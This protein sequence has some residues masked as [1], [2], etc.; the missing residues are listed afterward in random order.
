M[1]IFLSHTS[2][3]KKDVSRIYK[4]LKS[5]GHIPWL[6]KENISLGESI[7]D[8]IN[9]G[10]ETSDIVLVFLSRKYVESNWC[11]N[12][13]QASFFDQVNRGGVIIV[14]ILLEKCQIPQ[15]LR[16]KKYLDFRN[17]E[18]YENNVANLIR[19][20]DIINLKN[21]ELETPNKNTESVLEY[22][23]ELLEEL[24]DESVILPIG[25]K[26]PIIK[27]LKKINRSGKYVRINRFKPRVQ[28]RSV[29]DH[30]LSVA[31]SADCLI[32]IIN[33]GLSIDQHSEL[34]RIIAF[35]ELNEVVLGDIPA[36]TNLYNNSRIS[37]K[38]YAERSLRSVQPDRREKIANEFV[39]LFLSEKQRQSMESVLN[40]LDNKQ[41]KLTIFFK[42]LDKIDP[43]IATWRYLHYYRDDLRTVSD[44]LKKMKD[45]FENPDVR[46]YIEKNLNKPQTMELVKIFQNRLLARKYFENPE[47]FSKEEKL[48]SIS[49]DV[50]IRLI[51]G[52]PLFF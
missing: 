43:I 49:A 11:R 3:D 40:Y 28:I 32:P 14:P 29:F 26:I 33:H 21:S 30:I 25:K 19:E 36:Y 50:Y 5:R 46:S 23:K 42:V 10:I 31:H 39:W 48:I 20:L 37:T 52:L 47:Y 7:V 8:G 34:A 41:S 45:F 22:T 4:I 2:D 35:H 17:R 51:E 1:K 16:D 18:D 9:K 13:W 15:L 38:V 6:D 44:F 24:E 27:T 12:E